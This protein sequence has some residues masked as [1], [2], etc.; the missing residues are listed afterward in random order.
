MKLWR[1]IDVSLNEKLFPFKIFKDWFKGCYLIIF[2]SFKNNFRVSWDERKS[3]YLCAFKVL[4]FSLIV[5]IKISTLLS[6]W[7][8]VLCIF[9]LNSNFHDAFLH[10]ISHNHKL[11]LLLT[12][13]SLIFFFRLFDWLNF[14]MSQ[15]VCYLSDLRCDRGVTRCGPNITRINIWVIKSLTH[16][17]YLLQSESFLLF[18]PHQHSW[19]KR[20]MVLFLLV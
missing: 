6:K 5:L 13:N 10:L 12:Q 9:K 2:L 18:I 7:F 4:N 15:L 17:T 1:K 16:L 11:H 19:G 3:C 20:L 8:H 14:W